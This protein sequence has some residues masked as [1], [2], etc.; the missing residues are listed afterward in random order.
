MTL[1]SY[2][3]EKEGF[4]RLFLLLKDK[5]LKT[6]FFKGKVTLTDMTFK[7]AAECSEFF[8]KIYYEGD[9]ITVG[10]KDFEK[11]L[12]E[13][14]FANFS[15]EE[16]FRE[17]FKTELVDRKTIRQAEKDKE[18]QTYEDLKKDFDEKEVF[19]FESVLKQKNI[20]TLIHI[21][22]QKEKAH[23]SREMY[24]LIHFVEHVKEFVPTSLVMLASQTGNPHFLDYGSKNQKLFLKLLSYKYTLQEPITL[25]EKIV[26]LRKFEIFIDQVSNDALTYGLESDASYINA[27]YHAKQV[28]KLT[29]SNLNDVKRLDTKKKVV[30]VFENPAMMEY[31]KEMDIPLVI[32]AGMPNFCVYLVLDLLIH[33][34]NKIYYNGDFD[35]EGL[36]IASK[37]KEHFPSLVLFGYKDIY[38]K[39]TVSDKILN[40]SR[41]NKLKKVNDK[42]LENI[43]TCLLFEKRCAYQEKNIQNIKKEMY[44]ILKE[45]LI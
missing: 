4:N 28:L 31:L 24:F 19:F 11:I 10:Y 43:K 1:S 36:V 9:S 14:R 39:E 12:K 41:L 32:T 17:Y 3:K 20:R 22:Y 34:G 44:F 45:P 26:F 2:F 25:E 5:Y 35:P 21:K 27:F 16:L 42:E 8:R 29:L 18:N 15:W 40:T 13:T 23:F 33:S 38:Y 7:E 30:F 6:G 37:L